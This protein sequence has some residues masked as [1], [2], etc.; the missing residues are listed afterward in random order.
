MAEVKFIAD[1]NL[2]NN[3]LT[4]VKL[5]NLTSDPSGLAGEGQIYYDSNA[6]VIK[7]HTGSDNW[8][9]LS[10]ASGDITAVTAGDGLTGGGS[11]GGVSLAVGAGDGITVNS[12]DVAVT[13]A[14]TNI[15]SLTNASLTVG[16]DAH[17]FIDFG[18]DNQI[19]FKTNN[20]TPVIIMKASGEIEATKFDG[21]LEG[22]ADT[23]T[24]LATAR[25]IGGVSFDGSAAINLPGVNTG[26]SQD[27]SGTAAIA[28]TVTVADESSDTSCNVLFTTAATGNLG[29]KSGTNLTFN[30]SSGVLT[31]T[32]FAGALTGD[33]TGN[34]DT[35][36]V[37]TTVTIT[38]NE[39]TDEDNP[40]VFVAGGDVDGGNLGLE[41][42]GTAHYNPSTGKITATSFAGALTGNVTGNASGS[43][44]TV[45]SI[46]NLTGD[47][48]SSN[49]ATTIAAAA[50]HHGMLNDDI[51]SGQG[52]L[53]A[54]IAS[55]D[56]FL[57][58]DTSDSG[59][60]KRM[61]A[62]RLT[63]FLQ[64]SLTF[65]TNTDTNDDVSVAN[66]KTRLAGG[67]GS[68]AVTIG[69]SNDVVTIGNDLTVTGDLIVSG[70]TT[71]V[72]TA[73]LSVEDPLIVLASGNSADSVDTGF[74]SKYVESSTTKYAGIFRDV[75]ADGNPF[76]FFDGNQAEPTTTVNTGG[77]GFDYADIQ[78]GFIKSADGF[79]GNLTGNVTGNASGSAGTVTSI[80]NLTGD[81]TSSNRATTIA[82]GAV[83]HGMLAE[84]IISGQAALTALAQDD[85]LMVHDTSASAVKKI[86]YSN[87]EDDIFGNISSDATVAAGGALTIAADAVTYAKM[88]N[89]TATNVVLGRDSSGAG[90][91]EEISASSLR[92][93][94]NVENGATADQ[95]KSDIDGLAITTVGTLDSGDAT[96]IVSAASTSAAGKVEL[97][98]TAEALAG[99]DS[100]RAV[101][102]AGLAARSFKAT[103]G[104]GSDL[105]IAITHN[106]GTRDVIVQCYDAS[107]YETV[108]AQVVRTDAN[109]VTI[110]TNVAI[111][112]SDVIVLITKVD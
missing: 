42:D 37:A 83:H 94:I 1:I 57:I 34:A 58:S 68:N 26:G 9:S 71:T 66:L 25:N 27:T 48:T 36:T 2:T 14:N 92:T 8:V 86:T 4:N 90:V 19:K 54:N 103:I 107:S 53:G 28:T 6:N 13:A 24:K 23:A 46:G 50:V 35:A 30:S 74:Y 77:T 47:V 55:T 100:S 49:R 72:N 76:T 52:D 18:T 78:A 64:S 91:V 87:L 3:Q 21:A 41:T 16:R 12:G 45:T 63:T 56:E 109:N 70:D 104:D 98:T 62:S 60:V 97:A 102:P 65:T 75:S 80:G 51:I 79:V 32:G 22:N 101:T 29:P 43:A 108:Y 96:G 69:D 89:V 44:G 93:M 15:T 82:A 7:F 5:Q 67:F 85:I 110:D 106:L 39:D 73:T 95:S 38:D 11:S 40:L 81:V 10:S 111:G 33:V 59:T 20:E 31:A 99:S 88:Q 61:D 105:D 17:N 112:S 84:D